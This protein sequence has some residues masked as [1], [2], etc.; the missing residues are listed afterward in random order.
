MN[1]RQF[2]AAIVDA[3]RYAGWSV[4]FTW[5]SLHSPQ[6]WPDL[7]CLKAGKILIYECKTEK[8][9]PTPHQ[10]ECLALLQAA[11]IPAR[12]VRPSDMDEVLAELQNGSSS[13][14]GST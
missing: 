8:G 14:T 2:Q 9:K 5:S 1:E 11:G 12:V 3:A 6:G 10:L 7:V 13:V 4:F